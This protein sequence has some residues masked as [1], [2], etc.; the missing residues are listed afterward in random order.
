MILD[1]IA[2]AGRYLDLHPLFGPAFEFLASLNPRSVAPGLHEIQG[3]DLYVIVSRSAGEPPAPARLEV[4]RRYIDLQ[5]PLLGSFPVGWRPLAECRRVHTPYDAGKD[6]VLFDDPP[7]CTFTLET[8]CFA[9]F[10]PDDAHA[11]GNS[12]GAL[13]K[14]VLKIAV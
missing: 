6:A 1:T 12:P 7:A 3:R 10:F 9:F 2:Q 5:V 13:L 8:G 11:P 4:H 14:A